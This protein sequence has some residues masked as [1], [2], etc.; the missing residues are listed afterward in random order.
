MTPGRDV[1]M[2][3]N[4]NEDPNQDNSATVPNYVSYSMNPDGSLTLPASSDLAF[5]SSPSQALCSP[6]NRIFFGIEF[7][8]SRLTSSKLGTDRVLQPVSIFDPPPGSGDHFLGGVV[9]PKKRILYVGFP[10]GR[11]IGVYRY[12]TTGTL[13]FNRMVQNPGGLV[14]WLATN[15]DGTLLFTSET[16]SGTVTSYSL[17][18]PLNPVVLQHLDLSGDGQT[19]SNIALD[20]S[21]QFLYVLAGHNLHVLNV[22]SAGNMSET[23]DPVVLPVP[24]GETPLGLAVIQK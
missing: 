14:C 2:I 9:N 18:A 16:G 21:G 10:V 5:G 13:A 12:S 19:P 23:L 7:L 20:P 6:K 15:A 4:K 17:A 11:T 3:V 1:L 8:T 22:D 24:D